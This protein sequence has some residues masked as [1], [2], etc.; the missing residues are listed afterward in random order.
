MVDRSVIGQLTL[1]P[2]ADFQTSNAT[3]NFD[4]GLSNVSTRT[5]VF[6]SP[7]RPISKETIESI[8]VKLSSL[9]SLN[10]PKPLPS[11]D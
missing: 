10:S 8:A 4:M 7:H 6:I 1:F 3:S 2:V 11:K 5:K 9:P